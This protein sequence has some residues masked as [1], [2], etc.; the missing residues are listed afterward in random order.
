MICS[1]FEQFWHNYTMRTR[2]FTS[3]IAFGFLLHLFFP[4]LGHVYWREYVFGLFVFLIT[5]IG[6]G[7]FFFSFVI[8]IPFW[9]KC[10][11]LGLPILFCLF[12]FFDLARSIR[13]RQAGAAR[14]GTVAG[15]F[16]GVALL[17]QIFAPI[18]PV[19]FFYRNPPEIY[20]ASDNSLAPVFRKGDVLL[21]NRLAYVVDIALL[22]SFAGGP[23]VH[24]LPDR[25]QIVRFQDS[26]GN[27]RSGLVIGLPGEMIE[28]RSG[29][30]LA[31]GVPVGNCPPLLKTGDLSLT[32]V[33]ERHILLA[34]C[35]WGSVEQV[36][37][38]SP[39]DI[40][41]KVSRLF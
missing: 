36:W 19:N 29:A 21:A 23:M 20:V 37:K 17:F 22:R 34:R 10:V 13:A 6:A 2:A 31:D 38:V 9:V 1:L 28:V 40:T 35:T 18:S 16:A 5:L 4:G 11:L 3:T 14:S 33:S 32:V 15:V 12:S 41:G 8:S 39:F 24:S 27:H 25:C 30:L 7:L 26:L